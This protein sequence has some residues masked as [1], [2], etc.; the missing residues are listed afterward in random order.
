MAIFYC[1]NF[2]YQS[3]ICQE[4]LP[5]LSAI[6][7]LY[8]VAT[9][10]VNYRSI[11]L[12]LEKYGNLPLCLEKYALFSL[13]PNFTTI[14]YTYP[15]S[16][17]IY[18]GEPSGNII[19]NY[20]GTFIHIFMHWYERILKKYKWNSRLSSINMT[21]FLFSLFSCQQYIKSYI[22]IYKIDFYLCWY[23]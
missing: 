11:T 1:L 15:L 4:N 19:S 20:H 12:I 16:Y 6:P 21:V 17:I 8:T 22:I 23:Q 2:I 10:D 14:L 13:P 5:F 18:L 7:E 3:S 9:A